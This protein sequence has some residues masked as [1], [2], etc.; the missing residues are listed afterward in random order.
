MDSLKMT[1]R[2]SAQAI[3]FE[4]LE[5]AVA[6]IS[7]L[8]ESCCRYIG[9]HSQP[10]ETLNVRPSLE[11]LKEDRKKLQEARAAYLNKK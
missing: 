6:A 11:T 10:L 7:L 9:S 3:N 4:G 1:A 2:G 5:S 8:F